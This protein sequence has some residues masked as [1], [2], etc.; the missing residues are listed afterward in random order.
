V[1]PYRLFD[2][3][4]A[5]KLPRFRNA[6][7]MVAVAIAAINFGAIRALLPRHANVLD[8]QSSICL[9]LG[10]LPL[11]NA[12]VVGMLIAQRRPGRRPFL[13]G[14]EVFGAMALAFFIILATFFPREVVLPYLSPFVA[15]IERFIG[16]G[17][18]IVYIPI[19]A[20][21]FA[22]TLVGPQVFFALGRT[23]FFDEGSCVRAP[24]LCLGAVA[25][26]APLD[27]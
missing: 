9:V 17:R 23:A 20:L 6:W 11:A 24:T 14:F 27:W 4:V 13:V 15:P 22:S 1:I 25:M 3:E 18:P 19:L 26:E 2:Q 21:L 8:D 7:L 10:D 12:L 5:V 16:P